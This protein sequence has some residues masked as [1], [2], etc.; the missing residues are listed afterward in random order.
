VSPNLQVAAGTEKMLSLTNIAIF[1]FYTSQTHA[2]PSYTHRVM[3]AREV[4]RKCSGVNFISEKILFCMRPTKT[5]PSL[6]ER[7]CQECWPPCSTWSLGRV[8]RA[9][10][11]GRLPGMCYPAYRGYPADERSA[12]MGQHTTHIT[13]SYPALGVTRYLLA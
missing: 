6:T 3:F 10:A 8:E 2:P 12:R 13:V 9:R 1:H 4:A 7:S 5:Y 11:R